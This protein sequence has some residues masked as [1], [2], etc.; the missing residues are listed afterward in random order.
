MKYKTLTVIT[1]LFILFILWI[2]ISVFFSEVPTSLP[3]E[4][5]LNKNGFTI[6]NNVLTNE[7]I[8]KLNSFCT[9]S[10]YKTTKEVLLNQTKLNELVKTIGPEYVFQDYIWIIQKSSV[11]TCHRDNNGDFFNEGQKYPSYT[12]L[13]YLE[14]MDKC[15]GVIPESHKN[16]YSYFVDFTGNLINL[17]CKKG[18]VIIFNANL[19]HVGTLNKRDNNLR[20]QLKITHKDD[21][22]KIAYYQNFNKVLNKDNTM[23]M[24]VR[25][26]QLNMSCMFPGFSNLTQAENISSSRGT[27]NG[28]NIGIFQK[29]FSYL[30][31]G[32]IGF[33]DLPNAF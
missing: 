32:D 31:Y 23:P 20:V 29:C 12:M 13:V 28:A 10:D 15:L 11:H 16:Q 6:Y 24:Y 4:N 18:D 1:I 2:L 25:K 26:A 30:F 5:D 9:N 3:K 22:D 8:H 33:Y 7:E 27:D 17:P 21:I 14:D 19:I